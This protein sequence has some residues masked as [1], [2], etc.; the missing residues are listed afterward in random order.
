MATLG[1]MQGDALSFQKVMVVA[2]LLESLE[3][4]GG[5]QGSCGNITW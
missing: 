5:Q 2:V 4:L 3:L 1:W